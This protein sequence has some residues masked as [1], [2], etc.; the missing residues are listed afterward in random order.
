MA[1]YY[2]GF[3]S[4]TR[5]DDRALLLV[6][7][8][9]F[10]AVALLLLPGP[11]PHLQSTNKDEEQH[12]HVELTDQEDTQPS[13]DLKEVVGAGDSAETK[14]SRDASLGSTGP[15]KVTQDVVRVQV[16]HL[17]KDKERQAGIHKG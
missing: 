11:A 10:L 12:A 16:R 5:E 6:L 17:A 8:A 15:T 9:K 13:Q 7:V 2:T 4:Q 3:L 14:S 1:N